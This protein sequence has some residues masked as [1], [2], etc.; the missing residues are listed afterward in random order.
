MTRDESFPNLCKKKT[1]CD[2]DVSHICMLLLLVYKK[3]TPAR[4]PTPLTSKTSKRC[5][6]SLTQVRAQS[7][8]SFGSSFG[9]GFETCK[10]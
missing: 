6:S 5:M 1:K 10:Y 3:W 7:L 4:A 9:L 8:R 2:S